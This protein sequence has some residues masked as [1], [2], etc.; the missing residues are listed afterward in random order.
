[1]V[2][3]QIRVASGIVMSEEKLL[4]V[5][6][7]SNGSEYWSLPGGVVED[8]ESLSCGLH[9]ELREETGIHITGSP[10]LAQVVE[11]VMPSFTSVAFVFTITAHQGHIVADD[12][13][14]EVVECRFVPPTEAKELLSTLPWPFMREPLMAYLDG[15]RQIYWTY[16][17]HG[18]DDPAQALRK[19]I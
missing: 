17:H 12:P 5:R 4:L 19:S 14:N 7:L 9:R 16:R 13:A 18:S 10:E 2:M 6:Q 15:T 1:M 11:L 3:K 8:G